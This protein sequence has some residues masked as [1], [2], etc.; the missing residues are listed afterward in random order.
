MN[1]FRSYILVLFLT[2]SGTAYSQLGGTP[3]A[4]TRMGFNARGISM[5]SAMVS[6]INGDIS[7]FYNPALSVFQNEHYIALGYSFLSF[8]RSLNFISYTKNFK[9]PGQDKGGAGITFS[10]LNA[11]VGKIDGRDID[12]FKIGEFS[13]F[14]NQFLFAP[15]IRISDK[16]AGG[17]GFKFYFSRLFEEVKSTSFGFDLG[18]VYKITDQITGGITVRDINS[19]Y[20]WNTS[21]IYGQFGNQT[22]EKFPVLYLIGVSYNLPRNLGLVSLEFQASNRRSG[23]FRIGAEISPVKDF[24][25]RAGLDRFD[26]QEKDVFGSSRPSFGVGYQKNFKSYIVGIDYSFVMEPYSHKPFQTLT[27]IFKIK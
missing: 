8:D 27:A 25:F 21:K 17:V 23:I 7:G 22:K 5:G 13:V 2:L 4:F 12:G 26:L 19:K 3:G 14:E 10:W 9:I 16:V 18:L 6:V 11:G 20:E 1:L 24:K 15:S